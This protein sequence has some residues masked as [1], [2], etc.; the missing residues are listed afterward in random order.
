M[1]RF[2]FRQLGPPIGI[3]SETSSLAL[4]EYCAILA[5]KELG[6][7]AGSVVH[8]YWNARG[9]RQE[10]SETTQCTSL[11]LTSSCASVVGLNWCMVSLPQAI[12]S[13]ASVLSQIGAIKPLA[14]LPLSGPPE[15]QVTTKAMNSF[16][17]PLRILG[18]MMQRREV[19]SCCDTQRKSQPKQSPSRS[20]LP[21]L[22]RQ[23]CH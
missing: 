2:S 4:N 1:R 21:I 23:L 12:A 3:Q 19:R 6:V 14:K 22:P 11:Q 9:D 5:L 16:L 20:N 17:R 13:S 18:L 7:K 10:T 15:C 8:L